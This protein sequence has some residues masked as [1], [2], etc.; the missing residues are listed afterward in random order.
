MSMKIVRLTAI[1]SHGYAELICTCYQGSH[2][3]GNEPCTALYRDSLILGNTV[4]VFGHFTAVPAI[5][6]VGLCVYGIALTAGC[7]SF[8]ESFALCSLMMAASRPMCIYYRPFKSP[9][10]LHWLPCQ[11]ESLRM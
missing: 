8:P 3:A 5:D 4:E 9:Q 10:I 7:R 2:G 6:I 11:L 1:P